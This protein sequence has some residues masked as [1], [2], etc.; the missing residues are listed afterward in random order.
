MLLEVKDLTVHYD[1]VPAVKNVSINVDKG[2]I[3]ALIGSN[4]AGKTTI[5]RTITGLKRLTTGEI[6]FKGRRI[7]L[8][9][10]DRINAM[11]IAMVPEGRRIFPRMTVME[12]LLMGAY[13]RVKKD[14]EAV[15]RDLEEV[16]FKHF[17]RL[18][19]RRNQAAGTLSGGEQQM[20]AM[21]R[22]LMSSPELLLLDEPSLGLSPI[23][24]VEI[25]KIIY[26][27][28][29]EGRTVMLVEQNARLA[30]TLAQHAYV[31]ET[32]EIVLKG[33]GKELLENDEVK[34]AY[35]GG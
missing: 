13:L 21:G 24:C 1:K 10:P 2:G 25:A 16:I 23:L 6:L 30:L 28:H 12:N 29:N 34:R 5:L 27:I 19:E 8:M 31:L 4:G 18:R 7:D 11:G 17:P 22:A 15:K 35:L 26:D 20:L 9:S 3:I 33:P 14:K 32:G